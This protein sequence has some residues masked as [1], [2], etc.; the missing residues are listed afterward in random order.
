MY[1]IILCSHAGFAN[2]LKEAA[3]LICGPLEDVDVLTLTE[4]KSLDSFQKE[5][6]ERYEYH[7]NKRKDVLF[8]VDLEHATPYNACLA[9]LQNTDAVMMTGMSLP[10]LL[11]LIM[12][13]QTDET[14]I[15]LY[16]DII[17]KSIDAIKLEIPKEFFM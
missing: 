15:S 13:R 14:G 17:E 9:A 7:A 11:E 8:L 3:E 4:E 16:K 10:M 6:R 1:S 5:V 12:R 2:G